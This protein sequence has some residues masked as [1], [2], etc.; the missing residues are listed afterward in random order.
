MSLDIRHLKYWTRDQSI[1]ISAYKT[2]VLPHLDYCCQVWSPWTQKWVK[3]LEQVQKR[4]LRLIPSLKG[5]SYEE[6]LQCLNLLTL[7]NRRKMFDLINKYKEESMKDGKVL[8]KST[9]MTR[10]MADKQLE[11]PRF[12]LDIR[13]H[14]YSIRVIDIWN[15]LPLKIRN[16]NSISTFKKNVKEFLMTKQ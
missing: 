13:K 2:Y 9:R 12:K 6:K 8:D 1:L 15:N 7:E 5:K 16:S 14:A 10:S 3:K 11:K 4:A